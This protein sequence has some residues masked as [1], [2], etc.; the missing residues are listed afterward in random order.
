MRP[1]TEVD[2]GAAG[3]LDAWATYIDSLLDAQWD[4][5]IGH[6][7]DPAPES[8]FEKYRTHLTTKK[9]GP[10]G[11]W[12]GSEAASAGRLATLMLAVSGHHL[13]GIRALLSSRQVVFPIAPLARS[14]VEATGRTLWL[15][16]PRVANSRD[17]AA[18]VWMMQLDNATRQIKT[19]KGWK[20]A[21]QNALDTMVKTK[22]RIRG[23]EI[24]TRFYPSEI[25]NNNGEITIRDEQ[26]PGLSG[27]LKHIAAAMGIEDWHTPMYS[28]LSDATHPTPYAALA[29]LRPSADSGDTDLHRFGSRNMHR[30]YM[31]FQAA[32]YA[33]QQSWLITTSYFGLDTDPIMKICDR[34]NEL[35][36]PGK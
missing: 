11:A 26:M 8:P 28:F 27:G 29:T 13:E 31:I 34:V 3:L 23:V 32:V 21:D 12:N 24:P 6:R 2:K 16:D 22:K 33:Y 19:T 4:L 1:G 25:E 35:P 15:I 30:E 5:M 10:T 36:K 7:W 17:L 20:D 9:F 18:R 14:I